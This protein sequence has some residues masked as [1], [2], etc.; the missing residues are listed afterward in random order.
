MKSRRGGVKGHVAVRA[1]VR[2]IQEIMKSIGT[3]RKEK[4]R[5]E[6]K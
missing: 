2:V 1:R 6:S 5:K 3:V 4:G